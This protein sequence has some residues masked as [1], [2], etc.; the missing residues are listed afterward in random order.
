MGDGIARSQAHGEPSDTLIRAAVGEILGNHPTCR[1]SLNGVISHCHRSSNPF[2]DIAV[3]ENYQREDGSV[4]VPEALR[5]YMGGLEV[6][7]G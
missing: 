3:L 4:T 7:T 1:P 6:L 2:L 5:P